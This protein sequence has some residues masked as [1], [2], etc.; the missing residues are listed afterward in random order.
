MGASYGN[1]ASIAATEFMPASRPSVWRKM[2]GWMMDPE[3]PVRVRTSDTP[4]L[5]PWLQRFI[6]ASHRSRL[7]ALEEQGAVLCRRALGDT[8]ALM[9]ET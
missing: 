1:M 8:L 2:P 4:R 9:R 3:G 5:G 7:R 6:A